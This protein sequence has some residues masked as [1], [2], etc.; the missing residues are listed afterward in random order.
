MIRRWVILIAWAVAALVVLQCDEAPSNPID[1]AFIFV[2]HAPAVI[3]GLAPGVS[4]QYFIAEDVAQ[5]SSYEIVG[6]LVDL[7]V[8]S[9][10]RSV[11]LKILSRFRGLGVDICQVSRH[12]GLLHEYYDASLEVYMQFDDEVRSCVITEQSQMKLLVTMIE[13][14][15]RDLPRPGAQ[16]WLQARRA[17]STPNSKLHVLTDKI[18][19]TR[20]GVLTSMMIPGVLVSVDARDGRMTL[21]NGIE[22]TSTNPVLVSYGDRAYL[23]VLFQSP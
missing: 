1:G 20:V 13:D 14:A 22:V 15:M 17:T 4:T 7:A 23:L 11:A 8:G 2:R 3:G 5:Y 10:E 19:E 9:L 6:E 18:L 16:S 12:D 21:G